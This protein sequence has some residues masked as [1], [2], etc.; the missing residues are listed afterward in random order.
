MNKNRRVRFTCFSAMLYGLLCTILS[1]GFWS[2]SVSVSLAADAP[3]NVQAVKTYWLWLLAGF[4]A[5]TAMAGVTA[6]FAG[7]NRRMAAAQNKARHELDERKR[8]EEE[9]RLAKENAEEAVNQLQK[10][11][12]FHRAIL[13]STDYSIIATEPDGTITAF[14]AGAEHLLGY[15]AEETVGKIT[16]EII[17]DKDEVVRRAKVLS[18]ELGRQVKPGF[19]TFIAKARAGHPDENEWTY[20]RKDGTRFPVLLSVTAICDATGRVTGYMGIAQDIT[21]RK[22]NEEALKLAKKQAEEASRAKSRFLAMMSHELRTPLNGMIGMTELLINTSLDRRQREFI[23]ACHSSG[24]SLLNMIN[25]ILDFSKIEAG[26]LE[27][28][29]HEFDL[30]S[31]VNSI[32]EAM[33]FQARQKGIRLTFRVAPQACCWVRGDS[34]RLRQVLVNLIGNAIKFTETGSVS[35]TVER[36]E[37]PSGKDA[38]RFEV[39]DTG[40]GIPSDRFGRLFKSFSQTDSSMTRKY[41]GTGLG[42]AICKSL[43]ELMGGQINVQS[44]PGQGSKFW[45][46]VSLQCLQDRN[47]LEQAE[48]ESINVG[49][50]PASL[51][52]KGRRVL[53]AEDNRINQMYTQAILMQAGIECRLAENGLQVIQAIREGKFDVVLM[54]CQ[55]PEMDGFEATRR[56]RQMEQ[57]GQL[58]GHLPIIALS[59]SAVK[60]DQEECLAAGMD[61]FIGKP[62]NP[63]KLMD[64][65]IQII[66]NTAPQS[67]ESPFLQPSQTESSP[68]ALPALDCDSLM[69]RCMGN[70][71]LAQSL[72]ADFER[73][74]PGW[75]DRLARDVHEGNVEDIVKSAHFLKGAAGTVTAKSLSAAAAKIESAGR[76]KN[77]KDVVELVDQL[78]EEAQRCIHAIP[79]LRERMTTH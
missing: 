25:D 71:E 28:D 3:Q 76:A 65:I 70:L 55:M 74:L 64:V 58:E 59:A 27:L 8:T 56:I 6:V 37:M 19:E 68:G 34:G 54:D 1:I 13:N 66:S 5:I 75:I 10:T 45:F 31:I 29:E 32:V 11:T 35:L 2:E 18:S 61:T 17:H 47:C 33:T 15:K 52:L 41:G 49:Q 26:K 16:P 78:R 62:F 38:F 44:T 57:D 46:E 60:G 40:I 42:L 36:L 51:L 48:S 21:R 72:L 77:L 53:L 73:D 4:L 24:E 67:A 30:A 79:V 23:E 7:L 69:N 9:L 43:V 20:I 39:S 14:N 50:Q 63:D 22:Q 12:A